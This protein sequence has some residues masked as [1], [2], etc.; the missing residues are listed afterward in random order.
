MQTS[1]IDRIFGATT[2]PFS[3]WFD[4]KLIDSLLEFER[5]CADHVRVRTI[6]RP[7][8]NFKNEVTPKHTYDS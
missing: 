7:C 2:V 1:K 6:Q 8:A 4:T 3:I 5:N